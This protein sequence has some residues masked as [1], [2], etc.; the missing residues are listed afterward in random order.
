[1]CGERM[2]CTVC[3]GNDS[4]L[5]PGCSGSGYQRWLTVD[6]VSAIAQEGARQALLGVEAEVQG[7]ELRLASLPG[8]ASCDTV[9]ALEDRLEEALGLRTL[10]RGLCTRRAAC[11]QYVAA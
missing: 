9:W 8:D 11:G 4:S 3:G 6:E 7:L 10:L 5:C 1:M 2:Q